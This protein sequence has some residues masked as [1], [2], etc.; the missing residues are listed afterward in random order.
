ML[1]FT[2]GNAFNAL[3]KALGMINPKAN[4][5]M[6]NSSKKADSE[7]RPPNSPTATEPLMSSP[8]TPHKDRSPYHRRRSPKKPRVLSDIA[9]VYGSSSPK[10]YFQSQRAYEISRPFR[11]NPPRKLTKQPSFIVPKA[12]K[13]QAA[14]MSKKVKLIKD[15]SVD[16]EDVFGT[17]VQCSVQD[18]GKKRARDDNIQDDDNDEDG[19]AAPKKLK[20]DNHTASPTT[21]TSAAT[22]TS[23]VHKFTGRPTRCSARISKQATSK[24]LRSSMKGRSGAAR[25]VQRVHFSQSVIFVRVERKRG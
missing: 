25:K 24:D 5:T 23:P 8:T 7:N 14:Q 13:A 17:V 18:K 2:F 6:F 10:S 16:E 19:P 4:A 12:R 15:L 9:K 3:G 22:S 21:S 20:Q 11:M 1:Q